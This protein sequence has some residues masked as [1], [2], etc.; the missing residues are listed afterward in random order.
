V[1][2]RSGTS[3]QVLSTNGAGLVTWVTPSTATN[4]TFVDLTS[5]QT[6]GGDKTFSNNLNVKGLIIGN[7]ANGV[8]SNTSIGLRSLVS[9]TTGINNV[10]IGVDAGYSITGSNNVAIGTATNRN[11]TEGDNNI[12]IGNNANYQ[13][14]SGSNNISL[15]LLSYRQGNS[16]SNNVALGFAALYNEGIGSDNIALGNE[17][18]KNGNGASGNITIGSR[19]GNT[20]TTGN[21]NLILG[22]DAD[23]SI[24][25][26]SNA[27]AIGNEAVVSSS[28]TIQ[29]GNSAVTAVK[30]AGKLTTGAITLPN[31]DG[32]SGQ[33]LS[34]NGAGL[35][36]WVT[37]STAS[38]SNFV[39]LTSDQTI[40][41]TKSFESNILVNGITLGG[42][43]GMMSIEPK[44][45]IFGFKA[46]TGE[47]ADESTAIGNMASAL[48]SQSISIGSNAKADQTQG[49]SIGYYSSIASGYGLAIGSYA[50]SNKMYSIALGAFSKTEGEYALALGF[51]ATASSDNS[52][53]IGKQASV[54]TSN[55]IQLGNSAITDVKTAGKITTGTITLPNTDGVNGQVLTTNG[56]GVASWSTPTFSTNATILNTVTIEWSALNNYDV[57]NVTVI[58]VRPNSTWTNIYGLQGGVLGQM[59]HIYTV[60][61]QTTNRD[62]GLSLYNYDS[63]GNNGIQ[64][65]VASGGIN[66]DS[67]RN[68]TLIFDGTY[69]RVTSTRGM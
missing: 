19:A 48:G 40:N 60:N 54:L 26:L 58:F 30:T 62:T 16:G 53:A 8:A 47:Y 4:A 21:N 69:W 12:A 51:E 57:S 27:T 20:I 66:I 33:V 9:N 14:T 41:G 31:L 67:N 35:V 2:F 17:S 46:T 5:A 13:G 36:T 25:S 63:S 37:P 50:K 65:F 11:P 39:D 15:G 28:N 3:G 22:Y 38:S 42:S 56:S 18:N 44:N 6:V 59:I 52:I 24:G 23:V 43:K 32:T 10:A 45:T 68:T 1:L 64:K 61:D 7:G 29:L 34:T 55:T 49:L